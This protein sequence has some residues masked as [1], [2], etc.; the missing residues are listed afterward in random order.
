NASSGQVGA[1]PIMNVNVPQEL[2]IPQNEVQVERAEMVVENEVEMNF[3]FEKEEDP[4][5]D[6][7]EDPYSYLEEGGFRPNGH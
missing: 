4:D 1:N 5:E 7:E 3:S 6:P 2:L